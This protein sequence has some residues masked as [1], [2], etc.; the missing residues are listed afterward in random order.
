MDI[1]NHIF[2]CLLL[3]QWRRFKGTEWSVQFPTL[4]FWMLQNCQKILLSENFR[5][6]VQHL[7]LKTP[8]LAKFM[9]KIEVLST[10]NL[11]YRKFA[12]SVG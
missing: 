10:H 1:F 8:V 11:F 6:T 12:A 9:A 7:E 2:S 5:P 3:V 4:N